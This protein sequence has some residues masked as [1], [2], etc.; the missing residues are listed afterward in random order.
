MRKIKEIL[1]LKFN[2]GLKDRVIARSCSIPRSS[3]ANYIT[4]AQAAGLSWPLPSD[5]DDVA[6]E[7]LLFP[8][9]VPCADQRRLQLPDFPTIHAELQPASRSLMH[10]RKHW[11]Q[12]QNRHSAASSV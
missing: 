2:L 6:L 7:K 11:Q 3:I 12:I 1:R 10:T 9:V 8:A 4:R 5:L